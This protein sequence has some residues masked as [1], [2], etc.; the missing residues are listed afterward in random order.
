MATIYDYLGNISHLE[1]FPIAITNLISEYNV[2]L[3][4]K[5]CSCNNF[6]TGKI[7]AMKTKQ[8]KLTYSEKTSNY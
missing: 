7:Y 4:A 1:C 2:P 6:I 5:V 8:R 3:P